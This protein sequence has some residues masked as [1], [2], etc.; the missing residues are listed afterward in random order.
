MQTQQT[1]LESHLKSLFAHAD[2]YYLQVQPHTHLR[3][4]RGDRWILASTDEYL[5]DYD[6]R[7]GARSFN[8]KQQMVRS[9]AHA[10][11]L[12][13]ICKRDKFDLGA[14]SYMMVFMKH[15]PKTWRKGKRKPCKRDLMAWQPMKAKPDI[16]NFFKKLADSL[17]KEDKELWCVGIIKIW[18]PDEIQEGTYFMNVPSIFEGAINYLKEK[19]S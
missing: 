4:T 2:S 17:M 11:E 8:R 16:D 14:G 3:V 13:W 12:S 1:N 10:Q 19:L 7:K 9:N 5:K 18:I 15:M 6:K